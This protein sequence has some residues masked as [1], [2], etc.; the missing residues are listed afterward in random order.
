MAKT[1][2]MNEKHKEERIGGKKKAKRREKAGVASAASGGAARRRK[3]RAGE[4]NNI[5]TEMKMV[6]E[7][8]TVCV[9]INIVKNIEINEEKLIRRRHQL[10]EAAKERRK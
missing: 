6:I 4:R 10:K 9:I 8:M 3:R 7:K 2:E 1:G 5:I